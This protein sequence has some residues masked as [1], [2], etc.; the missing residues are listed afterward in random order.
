MLCDEC[1]YMD[2]GSSKEEEEKE[3]DGRNVLAVVLGWSTPSVRKTSDTEPNN[4]LL[5]WNP[6]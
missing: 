6:I 4:L 5:F 3:E 2:V 1:S